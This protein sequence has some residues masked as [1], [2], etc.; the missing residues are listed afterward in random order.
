MVAHYLTSQFKAEIS[1]K[2]KVID[3]KQ[4][5]LDQQNANNE[6]TE[7]KIALCDRNV[8]KFRSVSRVSSEMHL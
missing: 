5:F 1:E 6:E 2:Q 8:S 4:A 7:K 3:E